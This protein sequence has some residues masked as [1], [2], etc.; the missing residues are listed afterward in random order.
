MSFQKSSKFLFIF[1]EFIGRQFALELHNE[2]DKLV[3][4]RDRY[5]FHDKLLSDQRRAR[6]GLFPSRKELMMVSEEKKRTILILQ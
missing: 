5:V 6:D 1:R 3:D 4:K 2:R